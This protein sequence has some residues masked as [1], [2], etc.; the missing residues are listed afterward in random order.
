MKRLVIIAL[1]VCLGG[2][3]GPTGPEGPMG[4]QGV[5]GPGTRFVATTVVDATGGATID[6]PTAAGT[7]GN[8]PLVTCYIA[9]SL[10]GPW[11][12][13]STDTYEGSACG[14]AWSSTHLV[15]VIVGAP[16][17]WYFRAAVAW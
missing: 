7:I 6:L 1:L 12:I 17:G 13:V 3:E 8:P 9:D 16:V 2:C 14:L 11:L 4:P 5:P 10:N 15:A